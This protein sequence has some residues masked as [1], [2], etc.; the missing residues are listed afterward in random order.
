M[1]EYNQNFD[2]N[3]IWAKSSPRK[4]LIHHMID[5]GIQSQEILLASSLSPVACFL[6]NILSLIDGALINTV[7]YLVALHDIGKCHPCF[8]A[9]DSVNENVI[10][11]RELKLLQ[12]STGTLFRHE[13]YT[14]RVVY[15][16]LS[17]TG[18]KGRERDSV[19]TIIAA[20][21][22]HHQGKNG[23]GQ[24]PEKRI[25]P[26]WVRQQNE[27]NR[28]VAEIF[29]PD[30][31][32]LKKCIHQDCFGIILSG[33]TILS[34]WLASDENNFP[35]PDDDISLGEYC[36]KARVAAQKSIS[37]CGLSQ[38]PLIPNHQYFCGLW[39]TIFC[40]SLRPL[41]KI[42]QEM[43]QSCNLKDF[44][45]V[46]IEAPMGEGKTE[47]AIYLASHMLHAHGKDGIYFALPTAATSNQMHN[48]FSELLRTHHIDNV[49][50]LH[51]MAWQLDDL[52]AGSSDDNI[53]NDFSSWLAPLRRGLLAPYSV[54]TIDQVMYAAMDVRYGAL[55]LLGL[56]GKVLILDEIHAYDAYMSS[57]IERLLRWC[58]SLNIPVIML[59]A[60]LP[61]TKKTA[62]ITAY[63]GHQSA[64][65]PLDD[66]PLITYCSPSMHIHQKRI[67]D[68]YIKKHVLIRLAKLLGNW[69]E[70]ATLA[71][72]L[73]ADGGCLCVIVNTVNDAQTVYRLIKQKNTHG[74]ALWLRLFHARF[75]A[76]HRAAIENEC[77]HAFGKSIDQNQRPDRGILVSTQVVEQSLDIDF[78][79][80]ITAVAPVD[81]LLQRMGRLHRHAGRSRPDKM[82]MPLMTI[83]VPHVNEEW[84]SSGAVYAPWILHLTVNVLKDISMIRIPDDLRVLVEK[85]YRTDQPDTTSPEFNQWYEMYYKDQFNAGI[86]R[87]C[88]L[89]PPDP[90]SFF[91]A[92]VDTQLFDEDSLDG[93]ARTAK[94]R[95]G[96]QS[97]RVA[98][99]DSKLYHDIKKQQERGLPDRRLARKALWRSVS[100]RSNLVSD[101]AAEGFLPPFAGKGVLKGIQI[102][103][104]QESQYHFKT[105]RGIQKIVEDN[106]L[107]ILI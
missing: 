25:L 30:M 59:S 33:I 24:E 42:C 90:D 95:M 103:C 98:L 93:N 7:G 88:I 70:V 105:A 9:M 92:N 89:P 34:D 37:R 66:Y 94:T 41:Q 3:K 85:V 13:K 39:K 14:E 49:R 16:L 8:Q 86:A 55:R 12:Q 4:S 1:T 45:L 10:E 78:D 87:S 64:E 79:G 74:D 11:M 81:L 48:R 53:S 15:R 84:G 107:G 77:I 96:E 28:L 40:N 20:L 65:D 73:V 57:I 6:E 76:E 22:L 17:Q 2:F 68:A 106:E 50:L 46:I 91:A 58:A 27:L 47:A 72:S 19:D 83:L 52:T 23:I 100:I 38:Q 35:S 71:L 36:V 99:V 101:Q 61:R 63:S 60:T 44:G 51:S 104:Q 56:T 97:I 21:R 31:N 26:F 18:I 29:K 5:V 62:F 54:G 80:M 82:Q 43:C 67:G 102:L 69:E 75:A 32:V